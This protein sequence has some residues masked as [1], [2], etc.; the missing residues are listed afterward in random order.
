MIIYGKQVVLYVLDRHPNLIE[1]VM[2]SKDIE[3]KL[4]K[5]F[6]S[7]NKKIIKLDN[8]KAQSLAKGGNHQGFFL[9]LKEFETSSLKDIKDS[10]FVVVLDGLTD[11]GNIGA[12][13]RTA[14]SLGVNT[15]IASNVKQLNFEGIA[16]TSSGAL[17]D[18][19]FCH[20][21]NSLDVA[22]ELKQNGFKLFGA[23]MDGIDLKGFENDCE[24]TAL[25]LGNEG[26]GLSN[27]MIKKL[28]QKISIK[29][30]NNFDSLN[31]SVAGGILIYNLK[32]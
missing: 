12:I 4:F 11:V 15:I 13:C 1:E 7:L 32:K 24:K 31:V 23:S 28:D 2:F 10:D 19:S 17:F 25:V 6:T 20:N 22:N 26:D 16:K 27:K 30:S 3:P 9:R 18:I 21:P 5:R 29:M 8:K 14:Y